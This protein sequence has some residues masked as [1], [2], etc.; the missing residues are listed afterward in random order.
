VR[1]YRAED[2]QTPAL[3][4]VVRWGLIGFQFGR[5]NYILRWPS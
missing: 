3:G 5:R 4:I 1:L 2:F